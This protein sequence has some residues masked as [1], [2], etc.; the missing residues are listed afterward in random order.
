M[1]TTTEPLR[2][3]DDPAAREAAVR[4]DLNAQAV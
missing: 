1:L 4:A 3:V 2:P